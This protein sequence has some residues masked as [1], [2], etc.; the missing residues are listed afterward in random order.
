MP[1]ETK[2][3]DATIR[4]APRAPL[5]VL[6]DILGRLAAA[7]AFGEELPAILET[8]RVAVG[9][10]ECGLWMNGPHGLVRGGVARATGSVVGS[11]TRSVTPRARLATTEI[12]AVVAGGG[13]PQRLAVRMLCGDRD[14]GVLAILPERE[15]TPDEHTLVG[16]VANLLGPALVQAEYSHR[17]EVEVA[18][19][20]RQMEEQHRFIEKIVDSLPVGLYVI[21]R[22][23]RIRAWNRKRE[24]G[25]QGVSREEALGRTIFEIL[26]RQPAA[27]LRQEFE[28]V[29]ATGRMQQFQMESR[30]SGE[31]RIY[32][33][34]KIPMRLDDGQVTH[35]ITIGEDMT[36][37]REAMDRIAQAEKLAAIGTLAAGV[38]HEINNPLATIAACAESLQLRVEDAIA[39]GETAPFDAGDYLRLIDNEVHRCKRI[40]DGLLDFS[41]PKGAAR[42]LVDVNDVIDRTLFLLKHH[43][44]FKKLRVDMALDRTIAARAHANPEQ[45][46]Q[47]FMALLINA[48]DAMGDVGTITIRTRPGQDAQG[49]MVAEVV[50][51]GHGIPRGEVPKIFE[52]FYTTKPP[53]RGTGLGLSICYGIIADHGGRIEVDSAP[54]QGSTF[55]VILPDAAA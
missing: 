47:V 7:P 17:L 53:G 25:M 37:W 50:D 14:V 1:A 35:I 6:A 16:G 45:L 52:P 23:Y 51:S 5:Q 33:I 8:L 11:T 44:R 31:Q 32:R 42:E 21:D 29:F 4:E 36:E 15:L 40:I 9:A 49:A 12:A 54:G 28:E 24:T 3:T 34:S 38:M 27:V 10:S 22:E 20:T 48:M 39:A 55:R 41:R 46:I 43:A 26:H 2:Q 30:A 19:R 18:L 13:P